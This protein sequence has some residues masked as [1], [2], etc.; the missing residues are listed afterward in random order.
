MKHEIPASLLRIQRTL[1]ITPNRAAY[2]LV[3]DKSR[4]LLNVNKEC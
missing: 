3:E 4:D 2:L 1:S